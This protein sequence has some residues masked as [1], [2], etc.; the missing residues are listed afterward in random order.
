MLK[1]QEFLKLKKNDNVKNESPQLNFHYNYLLGIVMFYMM[2]MILSGIS[3][4]KLI[5]IDWFIIPAGLLVTPF[6]YSISN[7]ITEVYGYSIARNVMW[8]FICV[9]AFFTLFSCILIHTPSPYNFQDQ[10]AFNLT[11][12]NMPIVFV[13][14]IIGS[15]FGIS[16][17]NYIVSKFKVILDGKKYWFRSIISTAGGELVYNLIA[18]P[19]MWIGHVSMIKFIHILLSVSLFK[20]LVTAL[21]WPLECLAAGFLKIKE[22][23]NVIDR[24]LDYNI[25]HFKINPLRSKATLKIVK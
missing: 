1:I 13:A 17:N 6:V 10:H 8:W 2:F 23:V 11:L 21:I 3:V 4:Y 9:S 12:G 5:K 14:G 18:Y 24:E 20:F 15:L 22:N 25:F 16:F 7:V 19:L